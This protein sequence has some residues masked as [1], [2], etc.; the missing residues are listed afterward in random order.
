MF[1]F[2]P[3]SR[4]PTPTEYA[5]LVVFVA[6]VFIGCGV[7]ALVMAARAPADKHELAVELASHG[8][9]SVV[10]GVGILGAYWLYRRLRDY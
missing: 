7:I 2:F 1:L 8:T 3:P 10:I 9:W 4:K 6:V 5:V